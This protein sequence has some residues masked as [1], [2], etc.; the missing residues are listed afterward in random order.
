[1]DIQPDKAFGKYVKFLHEIS[2][3]AFPMT[4]RRTLN[5]LAF[6]SRR[7]LSEVEMQKK[8]T[9][10]NTFENKKTL[11][12]ERVGREMEIGKM[13][14]SMGQLRVV[15]FR[16]GRRETEDLHEQEKGGLLRPR[17]GSSRIRLPSLN[18]RTGKNPAKPVAKAN[19]PTLNGEWPT[20]DD[21]ERRVGLRNGGKNRRSLPLSQRVRRAHIIMSSK[22]EKLGFGGDTAKYILPSISAPG[23]RW[24]VYGFQK[25]RKK[26]VRMFTLQKNPKKLRKKETLKPAFT[27]IVN[28][29]S[30][31]I[32]AEAAHQE[33]DRRARRTLGL[34]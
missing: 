9:L 12:Y 10:R 28:N 14:S 20:M 11:H 5:G 23:Q 34:R 24:N 3:Y 4:A 1:M 21:I 31:R 7:R 33:F 2:A 27:Y 19:Q 13:Q 30:E 32:F 15:N 22:R 25:G 16:T 29:R 8:F 17:D 26:S 18:A 6:E